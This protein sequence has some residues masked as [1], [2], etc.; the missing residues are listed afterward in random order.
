MVDYRL[1]GLPTGFRSDFNTKLPMRS[2]NVWKV[3]TGRP[4]RARYLSDEPLYALESAM[5]LPID[6]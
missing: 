4:V 3:A 1:A 5:G 2:M 6:Q